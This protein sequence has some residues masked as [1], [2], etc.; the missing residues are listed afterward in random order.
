KDV[1]AFVFIDDEFKGCA[2]IFKNENYILVVTAYHV[3]S[4][5]VSHM[6]NC[7]HRIK[8]KNENGSIYSVSDCKFC[9]EKDI[10]ILYLIG[11]TNELNTIVFF[12]GTL[13]PET[14]LISK[15]KSKTMSMPAILY[16]QEQVEQ[17]DDSCFIINV[18]K[19]ILGDSS[20]NWGANAMEGI[21]GAGVFL[22]T[23]QYLI[24]TGIITS[25]PDEGMLAKVVCSNANGF[26]SL[27]S[28]LK[29]YNDSEYNYGRDVIIDSVNIMRK[30]IL[31]STIDEWENDSKNIEYA[32]NINR[33]LGV[34]HN[35][36]KL[37]VVKGKVIRGLMIGD[38][39]YGERMRVT[40]E[41]EKGYSYAHSAFCDK[42]MTFYATSRVEA[43][44]RYHKISDDYF[45]TLAGALR[46]LG[47][48]DDDIH[49]LCNR[50]IAFW[51][52]NCDLD[53]MDENDD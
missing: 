51:L 12:S 37:D 15:V 19:D 13:K 45:T 5:A 18:S 25:I 22:K 38:Y 14:D 26:L 27:E 49:M 39:L 33:K 32:N 41:F 47:L 52:A 17:H 10:A 8:I 28:S 2:V 46:P 42:D 24:L 40:P 20:G 43:N 31:D 53:F 30:E 7:F 36:N 11:G 16:S 44:N 3:I 21:S 35:K 6:D 4:T 9:A 1:M 34:L 29:A 23:H 50:D 48:S